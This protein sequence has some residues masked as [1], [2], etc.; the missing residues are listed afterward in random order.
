MIAVPADRA[1]YKAWSDA[2]LRNLG[3]GLFSAPSLERLEEERSA[4]ATC[5]AP[6]T[7]PF[8]GV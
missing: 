6:T 2:L 5:S 3:V 8:F 1:R 7:P 4:V